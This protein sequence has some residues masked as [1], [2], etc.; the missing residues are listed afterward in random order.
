MHPSPIAEA[1]AF[2]FLI[3]IIFYPLDAE[4]QHI[5]F[6]LRYHLKV[7]SVWIAQIYLQ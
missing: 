7:Y 6:L 2:L 5:L 4:K 3:V 1:Y